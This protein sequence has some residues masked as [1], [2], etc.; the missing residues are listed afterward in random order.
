[1]TLILKM[2]L[3]CVFLGI[4]IW[5]DMRYACKWKGN[6]CNCISNQPE[7][8]FGESRLQLMFQDFC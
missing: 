2:L 4:Y 6:H 8:K 7:T 1:M 5:Y 3:T